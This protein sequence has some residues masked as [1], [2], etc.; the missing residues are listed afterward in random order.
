M[1]NPVSTPG[2]RPFCT[3]QGRCQRPLHSLLHDRS[4]IASKSAPAPAPAILRPDPARPDE[5]HRERDHPKHPAQDLNNRGRG[6]GKGGGRHKMP[7]HIRGR[8]NQ[9]RQTD[10]SRQPNVTQSPDTRD[11]PVIAR[12]F[13]HPRP[14]LSRTACGSGSPRRRPRS[15]SAPAPRHKYFPQ[16]PAIPG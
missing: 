14:H 11:I 1:P 16:E 13:R 8:H 3:P 9:R 4:S 15:G 12:H 6:P 10:A 5:D 7:R 2:Q